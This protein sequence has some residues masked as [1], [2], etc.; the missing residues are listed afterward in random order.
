M[1]KV[2][3]KSK[4][5]GCFACMDVCN[6]QAIQM[7]EDEYGFT[8]PSIDKTKCVDCGL[9]EK[10]CPYTTG[11]ET[12]WSYDGFDKPIFFA[13]QLKEKEDLQ[14]VSSGG[15]CW[16]LV[17]A[18]IKAGG[19]C[20]GAEQQELDKVVHTRVETIEK[21]K[22]LRRS[23][24]LQSD[25]RNI[26]KS[27]K[28]DLKLGKKVLFCGT[29][30][31]VAAL[32]TFL[33]KAY[34]NLYLCDVVC[35]G[36]PSLK[37]WRKYREEKEKQVGKRMTGLV[38]R[39]K[40]IGW[41][42]NQYAISY[43]DGSYEYERSNSQLFHAGYLNG[44]FYRSSCGT[45]CFSKIPRVSDISLADYWKYQGSFHSTLN[46]VGVSLIAVN[47]RKGSVLLDLA[48]VFLDIENTD[49]K[50][51]LSSCRHMNDCPVENP[52]RD[53]FLRLFLKKGYHK[54]IIK[55]LNK[56]NPQTRFSKL[57]IKFRSILMNLWVHIY[58]KK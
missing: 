41:S 40:N 50:L 39:N 13:G 43:D 33:G 16:A 20:Y 11:N 19:V 44:F 14:Y 4:C 2:L 45:C 10:V 17:Q 3:N 9:C 37:V 7:T 52:D 23:K 35:H 49:E 29:G 55:F 32:N 53:A 28:D 18:M 12:K 22:R 5:C 15:A 34:A 31:Q 8:F 54:A 56:E 1:I 21:A 51:A 46:N 42:N 27:V 25:T 38:F 30:C 57:S 48:S 47:T 36:V 58:G 6:H 26:F 24:Y